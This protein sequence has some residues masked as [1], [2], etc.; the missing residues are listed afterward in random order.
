[1]LAPLLSRG[2]P[3]LISKRAV[4]ALVL[5]AALAVAPMA[6]AE[7]DELKIVSEDVVSDFPDGVIFRVTAESPDTVEEIRVFLRPLGSDRSTYGYLDIQPG[8]VVTGEYLMPTDSTATHTPPGSLIEY[9]YEVRDAAGRVLRTDDQE[10]LYMDERL[11]WK[12][13]SEGILTVYYYGEFVEKRARTVLE[14]AQKTMVRMGKILGTQPTKPIRIVAYSNYRDMVRG[15][16]FRSQAVSQDLQTEGM[17]FNEERVLLVLASEANVTGVASHEFT[18]IVIAEAA[19]AGYAAMPA[20]LFEG[21]AEYGNIDQTPQYDLAL[22]YA[23]FTRRL[24]PLWYLQTFGGDPDDITIGYGQ[25]KSVVEYLAT[26]YGEG[27]L[28]ELMRAF[29]TSVN[30]DEAL[31]KT[32]GFDQYGLDS[33][34]REAL[35]LDPFPPPGELRDQLSAPAGEGEPADPEPA[36]EPTPLTEA[37]TAA[38]PSEELPV[39]EE[40]PTRG[41]GSCNASGDGTVDLAVLGFLATPLLVAGAR[42]KVQGSLAGW[43][44]RR[45]RRRGDPG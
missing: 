14:T 7:G 23:I 13:V 32:F 2:I 37:T 39:A 25:G 12:Q 38:R 9:S 16:P 4:A 29:Q 11:D 44:V 6:F 18:H 19:G 15:L 35:G 24:K 20:W 21:L 8:T 26:R 43:L 40:E 33:E 10:F 17:A 5:L 22:R 27:K 45:V 30:T 3:R 42:F 28:A 41:R 1:M 31:Q 36:P 34:W